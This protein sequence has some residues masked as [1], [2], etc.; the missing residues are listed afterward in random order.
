M[1]NS[2]RSIFKFKRPDGNAPAWSSRL[3]WALEHS[4]VD[5]AS[6]ATRLGVHS[7]TIDSW[8]TGRTEPQFSNLVIISEITGASIDWLL[9]G[10]G[11][12]PTKK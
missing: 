9:K 8:T 1:S 2:A 5:K 4:L 10:D 11:L 6:I 12:P 3:W 7:K